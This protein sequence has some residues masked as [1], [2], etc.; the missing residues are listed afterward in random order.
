MRRLFR[1]C[2][3]LTVILFVGSVGMIA[4]VR[5]TNLPALAAYRAIMPGQPIEAVA[6]YPC[7]LRAGVSNG[8]EAGFCQ[9]EA[10][11]GVFGRITVIDS[12]HII[13]RLD[14]LVQSGH[15][16]LGDLIL[17]WGSPTE[18]IDYGKADHRAST[19]VSA[20]WGNRMSASLTRSAHEGQSDYFLSVTSLSL[21]SEI[22]HCASAS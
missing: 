8:V 19:L 10:G 14:M 20:R 18:M 13:S 21:Q 5:K 4:A 12:N 15:L 17:C 2:S 22:R 9:F 3:C 7:P 11:D 16:M 6:A 1:L